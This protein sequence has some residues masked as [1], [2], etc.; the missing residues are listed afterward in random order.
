MPKNLS[1]ALKGAKTDRKVLSKLI[2]WESGVSKTQFYRIINGE[3]APSPE[4]KKRI[5]KSL[6]I[7]IDQFDVLQNHSRK[8]QE[9]TKALPSRK[10]SWLLLALA[11][12]AC[13]I[14]LTVLITN[15]VYQRNDG[16]TRQSIANQE[17]ST[18]FIEDVTIPDGTP[19][20]INTKFEKIW[21][22]KNTGTVVWKDRYLKRITPASSLVCSSPDMVPI[23]ETLP[24]ET[25]DIS[26]TFTTPY[27][28]GSCRTDW[29]TTD[30]DGNL[31]FPDKHGLYSIV[32]VTAD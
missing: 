8:T 16:P 14:T 24:G 3:E 5:S 6:G 9:K 25:I 15:D 17:D 26:V 30:K 19:I 12:S 11:L 21:R 1:D 7:D 29:K 18:L 28:P 10:T 31:Y 2:I 20:P 32:I 22:V 13:L 23:P 27:L 4:T